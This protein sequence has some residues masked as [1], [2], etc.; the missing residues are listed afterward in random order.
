MSALRQAVADYLTIRRA[1][2]Y[3]LER[4]GRLLSQ[5]VDYLDDVAAATVTVE[6]AMA[7][8]TLPTGSTARWW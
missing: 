8:A 7:W 3:K 4:H 5:F 1:L 6:H 2:G